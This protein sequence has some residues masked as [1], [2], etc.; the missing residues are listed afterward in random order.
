[1]PVERAPPQVAETVPMEVDSQGM[2]ST[3][4]GFSASAAVHPKENRASASHAQ[5]QSTD[6]RKHADQKT[7]QRA[8]DQQGVRAMV[9]NV[10]KRQGIEREDWEQTL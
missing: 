4:Q 3:S 6:Q 2:P 7:R 8:T 9:A 1:M 5:V 10:L